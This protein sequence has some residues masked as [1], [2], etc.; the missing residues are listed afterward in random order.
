MLVNSW[1]WQKF[2][3]NRKILVTFLTPCFPRSAA[4]VLWQAAELIGQCV[5]KE[6]GSDGSI[7]LD[8]GKQLISLAI[9]QGHSKEKARSLH[10]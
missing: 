6:I 2:E 8:A 9:A 3:C 7:Y 1:S 4:I 5:P 10:I